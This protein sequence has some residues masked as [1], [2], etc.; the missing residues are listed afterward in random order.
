MHPNGQRLLN[1]SSTTRALLGC[2]AWTN[3]YDHTTSVL[4]FVRGV[5]YQLIPSRIRYALCQTMVLKHVLDV[6]IFKYD[7]AET[8]YQFPAQLMGKVFATIGNTVVD[9]LN[10]LASLCSFGRSF[11]SPREKALHLRQLLLSMT[12]EAWIINLDPIGERGK[13]FK[14]YVHPDYQFIVGQGFG[15]YNTR[16]AS[17]PVANRIPLNGECLDPALDGTMQ[18]DP[19]YA[20]FGNEQTLARS[21]QFETRLLEGDAR[22]LAIASKTRVAWLL[23]CLHS[24]K[25]S[26]ESQINSLLNVLQN[27]RMDTHQ[28]GMFSFPKS[29]PFIRVVQRKGFLF[30]LPGVFASGQRLIE[31]PPTKFQRPIEFGSLVPGRLEAILESFHLHSLLIFNVLFQDSNRSTANRRDKIR[32]CP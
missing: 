1:Q 28:F 15:F 6:Q 32:M 4:S 12:K 7:H 8:A 31:Y 23:T 2:V 22:V 14:P 26:L 21:E 16:Q 29:E 25:E 9:M 10:C 18:D 3:R 11:F 19:H 30:L 24:T 5:Q 17:I 20:N 27:L 13:T